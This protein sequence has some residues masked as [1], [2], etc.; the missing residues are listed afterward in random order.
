MFYSSSVPYRLMR[1]LMPNL[2]L[3]QM[4]MDYSVLFEKPAVIALKP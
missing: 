4:K 3:A 1:M 2:D